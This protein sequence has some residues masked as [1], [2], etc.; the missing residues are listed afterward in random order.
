MYP[1]V[2]NC[3]ILRSHDGT[4]ACNWLSSLP[5]QTPMAMHSHM[6]LDTY[7][8]N[9][10]WSEFPKYIKCLLSCLTIIC[11]TLCTM[12][13]SCACPW[14]LQP[15]QPDDVLTFSK[16]HLC[17]YKELPLLH[18]C[19]VHIDAYAC[20]GLDFWL[21]IHPVVPFAS[22]SLALGP[23]LRRGGFLPSTLLTIGTNTV[24][25]ASSYMVATGDAFQNR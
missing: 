19:T 16:N 2:G 5:F 11:M 12:S 9:F 3:C 8:S 21:K 22:T 23:S 17:V 13:K 1:A 20:V 15:N 25:F 10:C 24:H 6:C 18:N 4:T 7:F 14:T